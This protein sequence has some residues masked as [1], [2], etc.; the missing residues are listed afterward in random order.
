MISLAGEL[1]AASVSSQYCTSPSGSPSAY[2]SGGRSD[3]EVDPVSLSIE[4][5]LHKPS[6]QPDICRMGRAALSEDQLLSG[7]LSIAFIV[8]CGLFYTHRDLLAVVVFS[9]VPATMS[10][11]KTPDR[12]KHTDINGIKNCLRRTNLRFQ[13]LFFLVSTLVTILPLHQPRKSSG[14]MTRCSRRCFFG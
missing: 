9:R 14:I 5:L 2:P 13:I 3:S 10:L 1:G 12:E 6:T 7:R 4:E 11:T 8:C